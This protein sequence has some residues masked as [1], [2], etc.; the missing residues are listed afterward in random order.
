MIVAR[1]LLGCSEGLVFLRHEDLEA[2]V[3][4]RCGIHRLVSEDDRRARRYNLRS[5]GKK[6]S[7]QST[8]LGR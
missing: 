5:L 8:F 7:G 1:T 2:G 3:T 6:F 4:L